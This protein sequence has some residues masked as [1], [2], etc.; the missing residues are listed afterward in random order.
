[1]EDS[2][3]ARRHAL[4]R[5]PLVFLIHQSL[6][7][8]GAILAAPW[9]LLLLG[10]V[11]LHFG[12]KTHISQTQWVLY[13]TPYF[14]AHVAIAL[15]VG[16]VLGGTL[17]HRSMLWVW[18]LPLVALSSAIIRFP[19]TVTPLSITLIPFIVLYPI[20]HLAAAGHSGFGVLFRLS[21]FFGWGHG[22]Q[23]YDQVLATVPFYSAAA[24]SLGALLARKVARLPGFFETMG[25]LRV[26]RLALLVGFPWFCLKA[27][28]LWEE[29]AAGLPVFRTWIGLRFFLQGMLVCCPRNTVT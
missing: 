21:H 18:I 13:G 1:M 22:F 28:L 6:A 9:V 2:F 4:L 14:P 3:A 8:L 10:E 12:W 23:P 27:A 29:T 15:F 20:Q 16:W 7:S 19:R 5:V 26:K 11:A 17:R 24:Y 25:H